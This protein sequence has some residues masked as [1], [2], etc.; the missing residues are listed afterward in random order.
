MWL[1]ENLISRP[2]ERFRRKRQ[3]YDRFSAVADKQ[4]GMLVITPLTGFNY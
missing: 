4:L 3:S 1:Y 2:E